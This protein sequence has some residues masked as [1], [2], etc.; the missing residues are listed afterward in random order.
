MMLILVH[1]GDVLGT[2]RMKGMRSPTA[3]KSAS[4]PST[5]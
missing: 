2:N 1:D 5:E 3:R 4:D